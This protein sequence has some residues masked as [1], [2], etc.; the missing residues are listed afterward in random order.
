MCYSWPEPWVCSFGSPQRRV[1]RACLHLYGTTRANIQIFLWM[2]YHEF[3]KMF[4]RYLENNFT[5]SCICA[6]CKKLCW[7]YA[8]AYI[9]YMKTLKIFFEFFYFLHIGILFSYN[10]TLGVFSLLV[11]SFGC[12]SPV[13]CLRVSEIVLHHYIY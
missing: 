11:I 10:C 1:P 6:G 12:F 9:I 8:T 2:V 4:H 5:F 13:T 3:T 7:H